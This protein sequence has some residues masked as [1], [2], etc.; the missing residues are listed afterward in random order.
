MD[1]LQRRTM[2]KKLLAIAL[3]ATTVLMSVLNTPAF[4]ADLGNGAKV[5]EANCAACHLGGG[6]LV[7][8]AKTL[9][10]EALEQFQ[11]ASADA[12]KTQVINGKAAMPSFKSRLTADQIDD[13]A[14]YVL[15]QSDKGW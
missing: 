14:A 12:I 5:F 3:L 13:V 7:N 9:K 6:N 4:A 2:L 1:V 8:S 11:M 15:D 10:K